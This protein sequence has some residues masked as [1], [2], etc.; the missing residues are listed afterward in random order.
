MH[1]TGSDFTRIHSLGGSGMFRNPDMELKSRVGAIGG[2]TP[3]VH[4]T[5]N[6]LK[7]V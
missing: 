7:L 3:C 5:D 6:V 2:G 1:P 4:C